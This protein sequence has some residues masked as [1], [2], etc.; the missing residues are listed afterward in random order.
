MNTKVTIL[1]LTWALTACNGNADR[2]ADLISTETMVQILRDVHLGEQRVSQM[3]LR[4]QDSSIVVFQ[5]LERTI[6]KKHGVDTTAYRRS[7]LY[8]A[9]RPK[10]YQ[11]IYK[12]VIDSLQADESQVKTAPAPSAAARRPL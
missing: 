8:Y 1:A 3:G 11:E 9:A 10:L 4:S 2:P 12:A 7:Y 6:Y 5:K